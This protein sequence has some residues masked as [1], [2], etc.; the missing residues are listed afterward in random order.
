MIEHAWT[1]VCEKTALDQETGNITLDAVDCI[2]LTGPIDPPGLTML[3]RRID[4]VSFWF[5]RDAEGPE[6]A[7]ATVELLTS[8]GNP[9]TRFALDLGFERGELRRRTRH[10]LTALP[11]V[12]PDRYEFV[13]TLRD[14]SDSPPREVTRVPLEVRR[15]DAAA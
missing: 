8:T 12:G 1:V 2:N 9:V 15:A 13:V 3:P 7:R 6:Q 14:S 11:H 5:R 4:V 10:I